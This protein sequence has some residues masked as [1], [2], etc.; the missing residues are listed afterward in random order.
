MLRPLLSEIDPTESSEGSLDPLGLYNIA[1]DLA[2]KLVPGVRQRHAH[3]RFLTA[4]AVSLSLCSE[5][6]DEVIASDHVSE[7]WQVFEWYVVEGLVRKVDD[8]T[9]LRGLPGRFKAERAIREGLS[10]SAGRYLKIP[11]VYGFHG[12]YR[13]LAKDIGLECSDRLGD[14]GYE[15][16][17]TWA[18]EQNL[19]GFCGTSDGPGRWW[20]EHLLSGIRKGLDKGAVAQKGQWS[21]WGFISD[22]L[23]HHDIGTREGELLARALFDSGTGYRG[24]V[25]DLLCSTEGQRIWNGGNSERL[26]HDKLRK[27]ADKSLSM[28]LDAIQTYELFSRLLQDAFDD[29]LY[30]MSRSTART[31]VKHLAG[32]EGVVR[33]SKLVP[34]I[35]NPLL[36]LLEFQSVGGSFMSTFI[37]LAE[38]GSA[39]DWVA[40]LLQ[41]HMGVQRRKPPNG[42][43]PWFEYL[44]DG[45]Y[46]IRTGYARDEGG[47]YD[48]EY[49]HQFR[50]S[51]LQSFAN[52]LRLI[53]E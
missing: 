14:F 35:F 7:P 39:V 24:I 30:A 41:H 52:D 29:C 47:R 51:P 16:L 31:S 12:V 44:D 6:G 9:K 28:L 22:H 2:M 36:E 40:A 53:K 1:D 3:P 15:L 34:D 37:P 23:L 42:K 48:D 33:A 20:R 18:E 26:F 27:K 19:Q 4:Y 46:Y 25:L 43:R 17:S 49:A 5:F 11:S 8:K 13:I 38:K 45:S 21:G 50:T 32:M 10:L